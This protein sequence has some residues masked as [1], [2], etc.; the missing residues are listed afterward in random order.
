MGFPGAYT[1]I[2]SAAASGWTGEWQPGPDNNPNNWWN[3]DNVADP[4][5]ISE[6]YIADFS[7]RQ[8]AGQDL[9]IAAPGSWVVGPYQ[10][11]GQLSYF[12]VG[13]TSMAAPHVTGTV[14]LMLQKNPALT[15]AQADAALS[16][17]AIPLPGGC[18]SVIPAPGVPATQ[19][20]WETGSDTAEA[21]GAG[22]LNVPGALAATP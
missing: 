10:T 1:P 8:L 14:A 5:S 2:I 22:L 7:S 6:A 19:L 18:R 4:T 16:S 20:C 11:N 21:T 13:G 17:S 15:Q 3:A 9:D 12:F